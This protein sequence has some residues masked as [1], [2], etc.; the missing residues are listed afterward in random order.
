MKCP[1]F[2]HGNALEHEHDGAAGGTN[3]DR[4][5]GGIQHQHRLMQRVRVAFMMKANANNSGRKMRPETSS[6]IVHAQ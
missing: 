1:F 3:V 4:L 2:R 6:E 5:V